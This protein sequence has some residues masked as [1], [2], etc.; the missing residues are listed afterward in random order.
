[1]WDWYAATGYIVCIRSPF[2]YPMAR[3]QAARRVKFARQYHAHGQQC[4]ERF[5]IQY[6]AWRSILSTS[7]SQM[8]ADRLKFKKG[9]IDAVVLGALAMMGMSF[10]CASSMPMEYSSTVS[11]V[12]CALSTTL[13]IVSVASIYISDCNRRNLDAA[14]Q[15]RRCSACDY[16]IDCERVDGS[17]NRTLGARRCPECGVLFPL[18]PPEIPRWTGLDSV[19]NVAK[20][21]RHG[22]TAGRGGC[23]DTPSW[24]E[25]R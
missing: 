12:I 11:G 18:A 25:P 19:S 4:E 15:C 9:I 14:I 17:I 16:H 7:T 3:R 21:A 22:S 24:T 1:M 6:K 10:C 13:I 23:Q 8:V 20:I 5:A 2:L